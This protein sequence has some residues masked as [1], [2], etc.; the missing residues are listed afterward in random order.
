[1]AGPGAVSSVPPHGWDIYVQKLISRYHLGFIF[2]NLPKLLCSW[3]S[4]LFL[5]SL[6]FLS[7]LLSQ[8]ACGLPLRP[9]LLDSLFLWS[10]WHSLADFYLWSRDT[11]KLISRIWNWNTQEWNVYQC[12]PARKATVGS[13]SS[14]GPLK[15]FGPGFQPVSL[16]SPSL[17]W[18]LDWRLIQ[19]KLLAVCVE[20]F[21]QNEAQMSSYNT[22]F[23]VPQK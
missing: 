13:G 21:L 22:E 5:A 9:L 1:M 23:V 11:G 7:T 12:C 6:L 17:P 16:L 20:P 2:T 15:S 19:N 18:H 14:E 8:R 4:V 10:L 3:R